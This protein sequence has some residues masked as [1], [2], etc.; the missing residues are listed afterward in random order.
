MQHAIFWHQSPHTTLIR[1]YDF[2]APYAVHKL[3]PTPGEKTPRGGLLVEGIGGLAAAFNLI[4][5]D[6]CP[7]KTS[8]FFEEMD[9][10][11][12]LWTFW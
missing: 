2:I 3:L 12:V 1:Q 8:P 10:E 7:L 5:M 11:G 6:T 4:V 9:V